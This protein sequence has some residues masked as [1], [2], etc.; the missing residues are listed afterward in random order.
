M[1][2]LS[3]SIK[4]YNVEGSEHHRRFK[5]GVSIDD[6]I[7]TIVEDGE[8][9]N[10]SVSGARRG[11]H[12]QPPLSAISA[13]SMRSDYL[14]GSGSEC[15]IGGEEV[16]KAKRREGCMQR[17]K[18]LCYPCH[19]CGCVLSK[20]GQAV[21]CFLS[22]WGSE[23]PYSMADKKQS[24]TAEYTVKVETEG[25]QDDKTCEDD[26]LYFPVLRFANDVVERSYRCY[27]NGFY[28]IRML[29]VGLMVFIFELFS[30]VWILMWGGSRGSKAVSQLFTEIDSRLFAATGISFLSVIF[31]CGVLSAGGKI[32]GIKRS[33]EKWVAVIITVSYV[34]KFSYVIYSVVL[35][36]GVSE[37]SKASS[38]PGVVN[39]GLLT[40]LQIYLS[41]SVALYVLVVDLMLPV[42]AR[43]SVKLHFL[44]LLCGIALLIVCKSM[45]SDVGVASRIGDMSVVC[46]C[47][48]VIFGL[49]G[50][51]QAEISHRKLY[52]R[53]RKTQD[54]FQKLEN[55]LTSQMKGTSSG[56]EKL[57]F[58]VKSSEVILRRAMSNNRTDQLEAVAQ[59]QRKILEMLT[60]TGNIY[61]TVIESTEIADLAQFF[62]GDTSAHRRGSWRCPTEQHARKS[63]RR[64]M[65][66]QRTGTVSYRHCSSFTLRSKLG[67]DWG[68]DI[69][70]LSAEVGG[71]CLI[72]VGFFLLGQNIGP[73][74][75]QCSHEVV[76]SFLSN[77][78]KQY[79]NNPY[80]N[81]AHGAQVAHSALCLINNVYVKH[82][83]SV[84]DEISLT[85]AALCHDV[86]HPGLTN[87][88]LVTSRHTYAYT[89]NDMSV[90]EN[91]HASLTFKAAEAS[92]C[93]I[94]FCLESETFRYMRLHIIEM[95][96]ATDMKL[97]FD[98]ISHLRMRSQA[99]TFDQVE[100]ENDRWLVLKMC[101]KSA[102]L[103]HAGLP[104]QQHEL[105]SLLLA[106]EF[107][108]QGDQE[109]KLNL[110]VSNLCDRSK[111]SEFPKSQSGF[112]SFVVLP[113]FTQLAAVDQSNLVHNIIEKYIHPNRDRWAEM[114]R[115]GTSPLEDRP[116]KNN[117]R[118]ALSEEQPTT[119]TTSRR[120]GDTAMESPRRRTQ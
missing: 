78:Q 90:L 30:F 57:T 84:I 18:R 34:I 4:R 80:H 97:H 42:R 96:L 74:G 67:T 76:R 27:M 60:D 21:V 22:L 15:S 120:S 10:R 50:R 71:N 117:Y 35:F 43:V 25:E 32:H 37:S 59:L 64:S 40:I 109:M 7:T 65:D 5:K 107:F 104:W 91:Y 81:Q 73:D 85:I 112:I 14:L 63:R 69:H 106:E 61:T 24:Y 29:V 87:S 77:V 12:K 83:I 89:Y 45:S 113:L 9:S 105:W 19:V 58:F 93:N 108:R 86:G 20:I 33:L 110:T 79:K 23:D 46:A 54:C 39:Q 26:V 56:V 118:A 116:A 95:I 13:E 115:N 53:W 98:Q 62:G 47:C 99:P 101:I 28:P 114:E 36:D 2:E 92:N 38:H 55:Q 66:D 31:L 1:V 103:S 8:N 49:L 3:S 102:D 100:D 82:S 44:F 94:F 17:R 11:E 48:F 41:F 52:R 6:T 70:Q 75:L 16:V 88:F 111:C 68:F 51:A 119:A 72:E